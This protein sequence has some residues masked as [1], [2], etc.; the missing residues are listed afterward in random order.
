MEMDLKQF[1]HPRTSLHRAGNGRKVA[2]PP[3]CHVPIAAGTD[4]YPWL[5]Q[6]RFT[7]EW[8]PVVPCLNEDKSQMLCV[9]SKSS[10]R[11]R[12]PGSQWFFSACCLVLGTVQNRGVLELF[13]CFTEKKGAEKRIYGVGWKLCQL[14][15]MSNTFNTTHSHLIRCYYSNI[16]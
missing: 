7:Q 10:A 4:K 1:M 15:A 3:K 9:F 6:S 5:P 2:C 8:M 16:D 13:F 12:P 14:F 11:L